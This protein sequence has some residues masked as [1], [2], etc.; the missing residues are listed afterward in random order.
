MQKAPVHTNTKPKT[1]PKNSDDDE[2][3]TGEVVSETTPVSE[4]EQRWAKGKE[5]QVDIPLNQ[6]VEKTKELHDKSAKEK[7][8]SN[9]SRG[10]GGKFGLEKDGKQT[11]SNTPSQPNQ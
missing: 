8:G 10:Y 11:E 3:E 6:L 9:F 2:W 5:V 7:Y 4:K 1:V